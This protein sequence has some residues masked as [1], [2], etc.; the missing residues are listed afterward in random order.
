MVSGL[1]LLVELT[2]WCTINV[3]EF[4]SEDKIDVVFP[5]LFLGTSPMNLIKFA[6]SK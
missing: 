4:N 2:T 3:A 6:A 5:L 1:G